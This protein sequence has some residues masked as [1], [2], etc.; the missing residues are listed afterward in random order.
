MLKLK[1]LNEVLMAV[2][3]V[4]NNQPLSYVEDDIEL[5]ELTPT[6]MI[7]G[8]KNA[9]LDEEVHTID[10]KDLRNRAKYL[11]KCKSNIRKRWS[12]T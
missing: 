6:L 4:L 11:E 5:Q 2:K 7:F 9:L 12:D 1:E 8:R 10:D 3:T